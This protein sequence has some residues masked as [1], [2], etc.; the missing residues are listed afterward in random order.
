MSQT[1]QIKRS[2]SALITALDP[3]LAAGEMAYVSTSGTNKL[4]IGHPDGSTGSVAIGGASYM[5][6]LDGIEAYADVTDTANVT[7]AGALMDTEVDADIKTL[8]LPANTTISAFGAS[9]IDDADQAAAR[10]T[11]GVDAAGTVNYSHPTH[12]GDDID[13][14][15]EPLTGATVISD[16]DFNVTTDTLGH[17]TDANASVATRTLTLGNL[18][19]SG[20]TDANNYVHPTSAGNKHIPSGGS[21]GQFLKYSSSGTAVWAA[22]N[23]TTYSVGDGGLT[24]KN[25]TTALNTKLGTIETN[26]DVTDA[27]NVANAGALMTSGGSL[28][29]QLDIT[30]TSS[31][32]ATL[33]LKNSDGGATPC[34]LQMQKASASPANGDAIASILAK[35]KNG[36]SSAEDITYGEILVTATDVSD[37]EEASK[38]EFKVMN[39]SGAP[40]TALTATADNVTIA[41]DLTVAGTTTT[42]NST[43]LAISDNKVTLNSGYTG[44]SAPDAGLTVERGDYTNVEIFWKESIN[45]WIILTAGD[46][47]DTAV[48]STLLHSG[49]SSTATYTIDGGTW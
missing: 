43:D 40:T 12:D 10:T 4:Y 35:G 44:T 6:K 29:G 37:G 27:T 7:S 13:I 34:W 24:Q 15:T 41:G 11:L 48:T 23:D 32:N 49:N 47:T 21:T 31:T 25:F 30:N 42:V 46:N 38:I 9:L 28:T 39:G 5:S 20:D 1:I 19:Y 45:D 17:V 16:L 36:A 2:D 26:A 8:S 22:D 3:D 33:Y 14:D 18:G